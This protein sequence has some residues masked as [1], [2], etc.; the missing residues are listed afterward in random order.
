MMLT[1][2]LLR[3]YPFTQTLGNSG[4]PKIKLACV[5]FNYPV[6]FLRVL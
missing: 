5:D 2:S 1:F 3:V 6:W 4:A